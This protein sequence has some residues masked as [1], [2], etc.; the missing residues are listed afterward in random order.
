[1]DKVKNWLVSLNLEKYVNTFIAEKYDTM[2]MIMKLDA[3]QLETMIKSVG[4]KG[5]S[6]YRIRKSLEKM[7]QHNRQLDQPKQMK[8]K[9]ASSQ[10]YNDHDQNYVQDSFSSKSSLTP[11]LAQNSTSIEVLKWLDS[12]GLRRYAAAFQE[13]EFTDM[14][15]IKALDI[16]QI[17][18]M[19]KSVGCKEGSAVKIRNALIPRK[20]MIYPKTKKKYMPVT[21]NEMDEVR[22]WLSSLGLQKYANAFQ[23]NEYDNMDMIKNF[24]TSE[25]NDMIKVIGIKSGSAIKIKRNLVMMNIKAQEMPG[26]KARDAQRIIQTKSEP[27]YKKGLESVEQLKKITQYLGTNNINMSMWNQFKKILESSKNAQLEYS[28][29]KFNKKMHRFPDVYAYDFNAM[30]YYIGSW[31]GD[32][33]GMMQW[34]MPGEL[35][36]QILRDIIT[37]NN[38]GMIVVLGEQNP[39]EQTK[40]ISYWRILGSRFTEYRHED[41]ICR[42]ITGI[43]RK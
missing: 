43:P 8:S 30:P 9:T 28:K 3:V 27:M 35:Y 4:C 21:I 41:F 36:K 23:Y 19:I 39:N 31:M 6:A 29:F 12:L 42:D 33:F 11:S 1:M 26:V 16:S 32:C 20:N 5:G 15:L 22:Q 7:L 25:I 18:D 38:V 40:M 13:N 34:P 37:T 14:A 17:D 2:E 10:Y 24:N